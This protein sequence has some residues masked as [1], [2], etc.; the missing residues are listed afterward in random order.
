MGSVSP[1]LSSAG[2]RQK[3]IADSH[4]RMQFFYGNSMIVSRAAVRI[5]RMN[6]PYPAPHLVSFVIAVWLA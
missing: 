3:F 6:A 1:A 5:G 2:K 4:G